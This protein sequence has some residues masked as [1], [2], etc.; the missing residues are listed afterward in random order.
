MNM[1]RKHW[2]DIGGFLSVL[3]LIFIVLKF[4]TLSHYQLLMWLSLVSL[5][6]HQLEEYR[7]AGTFPGMLNTV[8]FKSDLPDRYPLNTNT[9]LLIN[10][11][12]GWS[13]YFLAAIFA[14]RVVWLGLATIAVSIGNAIAHIV[15]FNVRGKTLYNAGLVTS[16]LLF[17]PC[18]YFFF[19][20]VSSEHLIK[21]S[22]YL[23]GIPLGIFLNVVG[24]LKFI[25]WMADR[26]TNY[27]FEQR[28]LLTRDR[29][30]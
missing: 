10:V 29:R 13:S 7:I 25:K 4:K 26:N 8:M 21:L 3:V 24:V 30:N 12:V 19:F 15:V 22:D 5:F 6:L 28:N 17:V 27:A 2:Y 18:T 16:S 14:E 1:L 11:M 9:A 23:I 20:V